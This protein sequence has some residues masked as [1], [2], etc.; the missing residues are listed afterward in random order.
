MGALAIKGI[1]SLARSSINLVHRHGFI[2]TPTLFVVGTTLVASSYVS[3][4]ENPI[5]ISNSSTE[6][7]IYLDT[8]SSFV[9]SRRDLDC[10]LTYSWID[11][12][13][14]EVSSV[15]TEAL[16]LEGLIHYV[17]LP[18]P[19]LIRLFPCQPNKC[20]CEGVNREE[21]YTYLYDTLGLKL[22]TKIPFFAFEYSILQTLNV[23]HT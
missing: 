9:G 1:L 17:R 19:W 15:Y 14:L 3:P 22:G 8:K 7:G 20:I 21:P 6:E 10:P 13:V 2:L 18:K 12:K 23:A 11:K 16:L 4:M 5:I